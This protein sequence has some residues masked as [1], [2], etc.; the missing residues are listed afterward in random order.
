M[1]TRK[2]RDIHVTQRMLFGVRDEL[3]HDITSLQLK[4]ES[5][6]SKLL[7]E[8]QQVLS[9]VRRVGVLV[10]EQNARNKFVLDGYTLLS[11]RLDQHQRELKELK[12]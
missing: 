4:G 8:M 7:G 1:A 5:N 6:F 2:S 12:P 3:K 11:D 9:E 10:E